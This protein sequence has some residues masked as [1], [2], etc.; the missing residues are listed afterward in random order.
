[1]TNETWMRFMEA[2]DEEVATFEGAAG[3][4]QWAA[5]MAGDEWS[6][7][8]DEDPDIKMDH[9]QLDEAFAVGFAMGRLAEKKDFPE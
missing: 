5:T 6:G 3:L 8:R 4:P 1:M 7:W 2:W 9:G